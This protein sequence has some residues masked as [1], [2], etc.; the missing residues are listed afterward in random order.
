MLKVKRDDFYD[1]ENQDGSF[2]MDDV[3]NLFKKITDKY[4]N[5]EDEEKEEEE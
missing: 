1:L 4:D 3:N 5:E 2:N